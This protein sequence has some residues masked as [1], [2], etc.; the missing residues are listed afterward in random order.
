MHNNVNVMLLQQKLSS[1]CQGSK[2][3]QISKSSS[4]QAGFIGDMFSR[5]RMG[6]VE[7]WGGG[8]MQ[9]FRAK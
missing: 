7:V 8:E 4:M 5:R 2:E 1:S 6:L 9:R 3:L